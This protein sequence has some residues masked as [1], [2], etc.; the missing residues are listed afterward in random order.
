MA[1]LPVQNVG[2][3]GISA[4]VPKDILE[5]KKYSGFAKG[6][7]EAIIAA[8]GIE[9]HRIASLDICSSDL[10]FHAAEKLISDLNWIKSEIDC[11]VFVSQTPDY[12]LPAT[13]C[14]LQ[15]RLGLKEDIIA[16]D[17]PLGCSGWIYGLEVL[18]SL[19]SH[20][21]LKKGLLLAGDTTLKFCSSEDKS[22]FPLFGDAGTAT[23]LE[24]D[25]SGPGFKFHSG[26]DGKGFDAIL[27]P[28]GGFRNPV[29][30][31][32]FKKVEIK[33][34]IKRN[35]LQVI[36]EGMKVLS[37]SISKAPESIN[38]LA[39]N[40]GIDLSQVDYLVLH[41]ANQF[42]NERIRNK[43]NLPVE[44]VPY[45][46]KNYGNTGPGSIPLTMITELSQDLANNKRSIIACG[47]GV[48]LSW[49][50]VHFVSD[51]IV[52]PEIIEI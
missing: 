38:K 1:F 6:E 7:S 49:G 18:A 5:N 20:G 22:T 21:T 42:I 26:T 24:Y 30:E 50:T 25:H 3:R 19:L 16:F 13:S 9:R 29:S 10:C 34:G 14:L 47:F 43:L 28:E 11:L 8:I 31:S 37:F 33:P 4:C 36:L 39:A 45:S 46:L 40:F 41:Q 32:S 17:I 2:I 15:S 52:C 23:A 51:R 44:K 27:I 12:I 48:G 35:R